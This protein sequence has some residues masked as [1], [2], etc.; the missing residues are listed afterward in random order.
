MIMKNMFFKCFKSSFF[1]QA[2]RLAVVLVCLTVSVVAAATGSTYYSQMT[3]NVATNSTGDG[4]V[5]A[6]ND[7]TTSPTDTDYATTKTVSHSSSESSHSYY[8][9][10]KAN[11][12]YYH[13]G[14]SILQAG[15]NV[16]ENSAT[17][18]TAYSAKLSDVSRSQDKPTALTYYAIFQKKIAQIADIQWMKASTVDTKPIEI[19]LHSDVTA[20]QV[21]IVREDGSAQTGMTCLNVAQRDATT[22]K[23]Q[24][25]LQADAT[26]N[27]G[28]VFLVTL[29]S[30]NVDDKAGLMT[31]RVTMLD[32]ATITFA[33]PIGV[34]SYTAVQTNGGGATYAIS[35]TSANQEVTLY[36]DAQFF[37]TLSATAGTNYRFRRWVITHK[38]ATITYNNNNPFNANGTEGYTAKDG[39]VIQAEFISN[40]YA[41]FMVKGVG[42]VYYDDFTEGLAAAAES[43]SKVLLVYQ[44]GELAAGSYVIPAGVTFL[45]PGDEAYTVQN[46]G[47]TDA[48]VAN[49][50]TSARFRYL[51]L[52]DN[53]TI[54]ANGN[55]CVY[56]KLSNYQ[57]HNG[58]PYQYGEIVM[59]NNCHIIMN[60]GTYL[61]VFGYISGNPETSTV[62]ANTGA[63]IYETFQFTDWRGGTAITGGA[64]EII[65]G[66]VS[67]KYGA[68]N[69]DWK[70]FPILQY[71]LQNIETKLI[72]HHGAKEY[73]SSVI[74]AM[75]MTAPVNMLLI[76]EASQDQGFLC[77]GENSVLTKWYE[78][79]N[80][81]QKYV[82]QGVEGVSNA[83]AKMGY[84]YLSLSLS[85]ATVKLDSRNYVLPINNNID[86]S[87]NNLTISSPFDVCF[88]AGSTFTIDKDAEFVV[89]ARLYAYDK[90]P[91]Y[92]DESTSYE[93]FTY[94]GNQLIQPIKY[95][96]YHDKAPGIRTADKTSDA[97]FVVN[98]KLTI[99][100]ALYTTTYGANITDAILQNQNYGA[101][102][103]S[104]GGGEVLFNSRGTDTITYQYTQS[105][106][107]LTPLSIPIT[108]AR[109][110]NAD[111][112]WSAGANASQGEKYIY[113]KDIEGGKWCLPTNAC[114]W[115]NSPELIVTMPTASATGNVEYKL[116]STGMSAADFK[117]SINNNAFSIGEIV[118]D[119]DKLKLPITYTAQ[120]KHGDVAATI[121]L[122]YTPDTY[123]LTNTVSAT[124][125]YTPDFSVAPESIAFDP[126]YVNAS[127]EKSLAITPAENNVATLTSEKMLWTPSITGANASEFTFEFGSGDAKLSGAKVIFKP[128]SFGDKS[129]TLT[130]KA[131][132][133]DAN[134]AIQTTSIDIPLTA[135][136]NLNANTLAFADFPAE[137]I[138]ATTSPF[139]LFKDGTNNARTEIDIT[140]SDPDI[141]D[142]ITQDGQEYVEVLGAGTV[143]ITA[144][145]GSSTAVAGCTISTTITVQPK[146]LSLE[147]VPLCMDTKTRFNI[148]TIS[149]NAATYSNGNTIDFASTSSM[150]SEWT[151]QFLGIP[152]QLTF[153]PTGGNTWNVEE[154]ASDSEAW[155][156]V[157][158]WTNLT[159]GAETHFSLK[160]TTRQ[161]RIQYGAGESAGSLANVCVSAF[162]IKADVEKLYLP[163]Y[164]DG[165]EVSKQVKF[166]HTA[167]P[168]ELPNIT[169][170]TFVQSE[171]EN[172]GT[173]EEPY[174]ETLVTFSAA[175]ADLNV[176]F[177]ASVTVD[178]NTHTKD[179][180]IRTYV[181]P[182]E[183]PIKLATDD[184]ERYYFITTASSYAQWNAANR[185]IVFQNPGAQLT[186]SVTFAFNGAPSV[187]TF[188]SDA[189]INPNDWIIK[190]SAD[191]QNWKTAANPEVNATSF[192]QSLL[193]TTRFV[194]IE[195]TSSNLTEVRL[196][197]LVIEGYPMAWATPDQLSLSE[198][199]KTASFVL[200][201]ANLQN[202]KVVLDNNDFSLTHG[203]N[204]EEKTEI[205]LSASDYADALGVNKV[206]E[207]TF[208]VIWKSTGNVNQ[209]LISI[210]NA[211]DNT[212]LTTVKIVGSKDAITVEDAQ[213]GIYTGIPSGYTS[214][215]GADYTHHEVNIKNAFAT[216]GTALFDYLIIY[217]ETTTQDG[218]TAITSPTSDMGSN[219][220]T[221]YYIYEKALNTTKNTYDSY[222]FIQLVE[223][224][225]VANKAE[226]N[227]FT[228]TATGNLPSIYVDIQESLRVY[229]TGFC[230]F[231][232]TGST[233][234]QEGVWFFRGTNGETLDIYLE[235]C[236][237]YSRNKTK[238]G[239]PMN[240]SDEGASTFTGDYAL[241]SGGVLVFENTES[242]D[243][244]ETAQPFEVNIHTIGH[245]V[246]K[247]NYGSFYEIFGMRAYQ[248][249]APLHIHMNSAKHV[250]SSKT[251]LTLDDVW[252]TMLDAN[253]VMADSVR[254]NG[255]LSLQKQSNNAPSIDLGNPHSVVNFRGGQVELQNAQIVSPNYKTTLAIS[256]RSGEYGGD[257]VGIKFAYGIGTDSV[258]GTVNF[259]DGTTTVLPMTVDEKYRQYYLMD[260]D[261]VHT[262]CLRCP[263]N[264]YVYGGSQCFMRACSHVTS[265]GGA[266]TDGY[267]QLG[268]YIYTFGAED[269]DAKDEKGLVKSI[270]FPGY[271]AGLSE[272]YASKGYQ[273]NIASIT[274]DEDNK[275]YFWVPDGYGD[276]EA[277][278]DKLL[279]TWKAC[280]T[281]IHA[282]YQTK[283]GAIGGNTP[284]EPT[285]EVKYLLY[286]QIDENIHNIISAG[287]KDADG[288]VVN[289]HYKAPV[290]VPDVAQGFAGGKYMSLA[291]TY[292]G[293]DKE[294]EVMSEGDYT[295]TDKVY[296]ITTA[297]ADVW[298]TFTAPFDVEKIWVVE[299][300]DEVTLEQTPIK[301]DKDNKP[302]THRQSVLLEQAKHNADFASF[303]GVAMALGSA[304]DFETIFKD[305]KEWGIEQDKTAPEGG[306]ALYSG[307]GN[308]TLRDKYELIPYD[309]SNWN[310]AQFYLNHNTGK[311]DY[312]YDDELGEV[313]IPEWKVP[314]AAENS[315]GILLEKG[316]TYS[317]L[318]P[319]CT[320][321][322]EMDEYGVAKDREYW[323]YWSG[324]FLIFEGKAGN[325]TI[326]GSDFLFE[327]NTDGVFQGE[328]LLT[329]VDADLRGNS[330]FAFMNT[331]KENVYAYAAAPNAEAFMWES[332]DMKTIL[333]TNSFLLLQDYL[334]DMQ[335]MPA[336]SI[337]R[338]GKIN[339][340]KGNTPS[341]TQ[342][343]NIPTIN[344]GSDIFVTEV[345]S[346][347]NIAVAA[348][349]YVRVL[350]SAGALLYNGMVETSV[351]VNLPNNGIYVVAGE[352]TS[353]KIMH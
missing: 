302:L 351:D 318:F 195:Y 98:G 115:S 345:A 36:N 53:T 88:L 168:L 99:N 63:T 200:T 253:R 102:I 296:Y 30:S 247:S 319:Y 280:M 95:T 105:G 80:D 5:W 218:S 217:G 223:N 107:T 17:G 257:D 11:D 129:A 41:R 136:A 349:Q 174:Y 24:I 246:F 57:G 199:Q 93:G 6:T 8:L 141:I 94:S 336:K 116:R 71:Y 220:L 305:W 308:Y 89:D 151:F 252:P 84:M 64:S 164:A 211:D 92:V 148:H 295:I 159:A 28:D 188:D 131:T 335:G 163:I 104:N 56:S 12:G 38:D 301:T 27:A 282:G 35:N 270:R 332:V 77:L 114:T 58:R 15:T 205:T 231:A 181:V 72:I 142:I 3:V 229:M 263:K 37:H 34:G 234:N 314:T 245:N 76:S 33:T 108:N 122:T 213:T 275:L 109:L 259:Y 184:A 206:G 46:N 9:Y 339:Y 320:G 4:L 197:N 334:T 26:V 65:G 43:N 117:A 67:G 347:I 179:I 83:T 143:T 226:V 277:E 297:T 260:E 70:I 317:M 196:S 337:S 194:T 130:L 346:G 185:Q 310:T 291:P 198:N 49:N 353:I 100:G 350:S 135:S 309:G 202:I 201:T 29:S 232:T 348:P 240:K 235:D 161:V 120:N 251:E 78:A 238:T 286:C 31:F 212:L 190:E 22:G 228:T 182:Q 103:T 324:K 279:T 55:I 261:G 165:T 134:D 329:N 155:S 54:T 170:I 299:T 126:I 338:T 276:V 258:G 75:D 146:S 39:D 96:A 265:K 342:N 233:Q 289:Y 32:N 307:T 138:E 51:T 333:P 87:V 97:S 20:L 140:L 139:L 285:E 321:C 173:P 216:D 267:S 283:T 316:E 106:T 172:K 144:M 42:G 176:T 281:E 287:D 183:L 250:R 311:W 23:G 239:A 60:S 127:A 294:H 225:N 203:S 2:P 10:A 209:G 177:T 157:V 166:T 204:A 189:N 284:I 158:T 340:G 278:K 162:T 91:I 323:D 272:Y 180:A 45:V 40:T 312:S 255:F 73:V 262:S 313:F 21:S 178:E 25:T 86:I 315:D 215:F 153:I 68:I 1:C 79:E 300:Y 208:N 273:Y 268:Q 210:Y 222:R 207:I 191:G 292:V 249:S 147:R 341:G 13:A 266:P 171:S 187:I 236:H 254:T 331:A 62:T 352:N 111:K 90:E 18:T 326:H 119:G 19:T 112:S 290:K 59:G 214:A 327:S 271:I 125:N 224:A 248:I 293:K 186:R 69:N 133:T 343:G 264:T 145:Q 322:W 16:L 227:G 152:D 113:Y 132:Y 325:Q 7:N 121:T 85:I 154:R 50:T 328:E 330:T 74:E 110:R 137:I 156:S 81:R 14:W 175:Q 192:E 128:T 123:S 150:S 47:V 274:P 298:M 237:I 52:Q 230:P 242:S 66:L 82:I 288:N 221:P 124:E 306:S 241:G 244:L 219:A 304:D 269:G 101:N 61:T 193:Y 118:I 243:N 303:F 149:A 167:T 344:G 169:G 44:S 256:Y 48:E 160:P